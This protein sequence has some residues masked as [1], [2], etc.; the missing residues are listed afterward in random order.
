MSERPPFARSAPGAAMSE[1]CADGRLRLQVCASCGA[2]QYP[3]REV[4][5]SCLGGDLAWQ[6]V[7]TGGRVLS[8]TR[9]HASALGYF[10]SRLPWTVGMVQ[11]DAGPRALVHLPARLCAT[12]AAVDVHAVADASGRRVLLAWTPGAA[13]PADA[14]LDSLMQA[15]TGQEQP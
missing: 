4:C 9:G 6:P 12:G 11:L 14:H 8:W 5:S 13:L 3:P 10:H 1:A 2:T 15:Q 7:A